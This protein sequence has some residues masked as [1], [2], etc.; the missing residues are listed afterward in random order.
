MSLAAP[1]LDFEAH[2]G[3]LHA[4]L[5]LLSVRKE[6]ESLASAAAAADRPPGD[7]GLVPADSGPE[8]AV[9]LALLGVLSLGG[10]VQ[11]IAEAWAEE[12]RAEELPPRA[13][14]PAQRVEDILR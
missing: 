6:I 2:D 9:L 1:E 12:P 10:R 5:G 8:D 3:F 13:K 4:M 14:A 7:S 11:R